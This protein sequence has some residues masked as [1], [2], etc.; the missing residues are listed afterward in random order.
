MVT[1]VVTHWDQANN[2]V[3]PKAEKILTTEILPTSG[4]KSILFSGNT[5]E[6]K[7]LCK[8][9]DGLFTTLINIQITS[10]EF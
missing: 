3:R 5:I 6:G 10:T 2:N 8:Q 7:S 1:I 4:V 9:I